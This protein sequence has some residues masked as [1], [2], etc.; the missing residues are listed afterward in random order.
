MN[1][2]NGSRRKHRFEAFFLK[3]YL[4]GATL[5]IRRIT[6]HVCNIFRKLDPSSGTRKLRLIMRMHKVQ[7]DAANA[8][9]IGNSMRKNAYRFYD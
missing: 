3:A 8:V 1:K 2:F 6:Q 9:N 5:S 7:E 4:I